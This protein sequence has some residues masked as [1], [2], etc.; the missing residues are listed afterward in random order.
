MIR[1]KRDNEKVNLLFDSDLPFDCAGDTVVT[2]DFSCSTPQP[3]YA[4]LATNYLR[5]RLLAEMQRI[6]RKAYEK[7]W[8][9]ARAKRKKE[10]WFS[11]N[12]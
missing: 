4:Q 1:I 3:Y 11:G 10:D 6:R 7:G 2:F 5:E 12:L 8:R 9:D